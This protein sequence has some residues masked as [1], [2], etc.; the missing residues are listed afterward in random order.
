MLSI[1]FFL[2]FCIFVFNVHRFI[3]ALCLQFSF[4]FT[5][6]FP[7]ST[8]K[9]LEFFYFLFEGV[10]WGSLDFPFLRILGWISLDVGN[11][12]KSSSLSSF[13]HPFPLLFIYLFTLYTLSFSFYPLH[14]II[15]F[16]RSS[17]FVTQIRLNRFVCSFRLFVCL[18]VCLFVWYPFKCFLF[19]VNCSIF[20]SFWF[21]ISTVSIHPSIHP[22]IHSDIQITRI[23]SIP[24]P[25]PHTPVHL[26]TSQY[27]HTYIQNIYILGLFL[28]VRTTESWVYHRVPSTVL[29]PGVI[30]A[31][32]QYCT[33]FVLS[34][35][36]LFIRLGTDICMRNLGR[37]GSGFVE[38]SIL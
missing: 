8:G 30:Y 13:F 35:V 10:G 12:V 14:F 17:F 27:K 4:I 19:L 7:L 20:V 3:F 16:Y 2:L 32:Q 36:R 24:H 26:Y 1:L 23:Q 18:F 34:M 31:D 28:C 25:H 33:Y 11:Q 29:S 6:A 21:R 9:R 38:D 15:F 5:P 37:D 22:P